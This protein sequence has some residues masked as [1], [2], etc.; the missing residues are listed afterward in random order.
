MKNLLEKAFIAAREGET[1]GGIG[2]VKEY[3]Y[4]EFE[5]WFDTHE[6][7]VLKK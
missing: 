1:I 2:G 3:K 6:I 4:K 7:V 5:D